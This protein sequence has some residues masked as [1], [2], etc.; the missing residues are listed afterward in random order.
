MLEV[1][2][3]Q[4]LEPR[5]EAVAAAAPTNVKQLQPPRA[6]SPMH[7]SSYDDNME[8]A[9]PMGKDAADDIPF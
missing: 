8:P 1:D 5:Q 6:E 2:D 9:M 4:Y 3:F 7:E